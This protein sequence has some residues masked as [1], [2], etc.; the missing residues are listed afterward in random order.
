MRR[1]LVLAG[2]LAMM[3]GLHVLRA[4]VATGPVD[5]LTLAAV[6]FVILAAFTV[7]EVGSSLG[8]PKVTGFIV[9]GVALGPSVSDI[10]SERVVS[11]LGMFNTLALGLIATHAGLELDLAAIRRISRTLLATV[12]AK[13]LLLPLAV[14]VPLFVVQRV[15]PVLP[16]EGVAANAVLAAL[17]SVLAIG[18]SPA[19]ALA[20]ID[21]ARARGRLAD[22][23][24]AIAVVKDL[25]VVVCLAAAIAVSRVV[26]AGGGELEPTVLLDLAQEIGASLVVGGAV[27]L[28]LIQYIRRVRAEMLLAVLVMILVVAEV[29]EVLHLELLLVF[30]AAGFVV[31][32]LSDCEHELVAA[33]EHISLPIYVVFFTTAGGRIDLATT[34]ALLPLALLLAAGRSGAFAVAGR[35]GCRFGGESQLVARNAWLAFLPQ[36]GVTLGLVLLSSEA[37]PTLYEPILRLGMA[38][39]AVNLLVGPVTLA[40]ALRRA[41]ETPGHKLA[42]APEAVPAE[43]TAPASL[44][45]APTIGVA[46][47]VR[48]EQLAACFDR[49]C[50][51][52]AADRRDLVAAEV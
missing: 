27:G 22:L 31:R 49:L 36:A 2:A 41:G 4:Q 23:T 44:P 37:L 46:A 18:T 50:E 42:P 7:G 24:L 10:L 48:D 52:L 33:L 26:L 29:S 47:V 35:V 38:L 32:N 45:P 39:V 15:A 28:V 21:D 17:V 20:V 3:S 12:G 11:E 51:D 6:G 16:V 5:A 25:V 8:L 43:V 14:G 30:I 19:I 40:L 34:V 13:L 1:L 9:A